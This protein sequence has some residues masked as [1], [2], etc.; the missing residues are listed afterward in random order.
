MPTLLVLDHVEGTE[1]R[2]LWAVAG[3]LYPSCFWISYTL[4]SSQ[5]SSLWSYIVPASFRDDGAAGTILLAW[6]LPKAS[7]SH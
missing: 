2:W 4:P 3:S 5:G 7:S 1:F 6:P